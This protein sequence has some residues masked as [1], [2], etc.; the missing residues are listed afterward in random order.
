MGRRTRKRIHKK[1]KGTRKR[2][3]SSH[4]MKFFNWW[5]NTQGNEE[6]SES[7]MQY[8]QEL[9]KGCSNKFK[10]V[11]IYSVFPPVSKDNDVTTSDDILTFQYSGE[12]ML[13]ETSKFKINIGPGED[14]HENIIVSPYM[15]MYMW[16]DNPDFSP[17]T[18]LRKHMRPQNKFCLFAVSNEA[19]ER[20]DFFHKLS[21]YK[22]VDS[23]GSILNNLGKKCPG[24]NYD[25]KEYHDFIGDYKFMICFENTSKKNYMT[26][27]LFIAY[28]SGTIP[29]YWGCPNIGDYVNVDSILYLKPDFS[30]ADVSKL[31]SDI[32]VL[33]ND[34]NLYKKKF[35]SIFFK[36]GVIPDEFNMDVI[37]SKVC[38][39]VGGSKQL[40]IA[41]Y[42]NSL[43]E[44]G[45]SIALFD[46][47][48]FNQSLLNNKSIIIYNKNSD[49]N[50]DK[51]VD[52]FND[53]FDVFSISSDLNVQEID[54]ILYEEKCDIIYIIYNGVRI[55]VPKNAK[56]CAHCVFICVE[57]KV[58][59]VYA[60]IS[61]YVDG[62]DG[63]YPIVPHMINLPSH[64]RNMR[65]KLSIPVNATVFGRY[66]GN[67]TFD[68]DYVHKAV[69]EVAKRNNNIYF[70]FANTDT[71]CDDLPNIIHLEAVI[72]A[73]EKVEFI[74][75]CDAMLW[76]GLKGETFGLAIGEFSTK[77]KPVFVTEIGVKGFVDILKDK[78][79][80]YNK[81]TLK[82]L[83]INFNKEDYK[84][85][86]LN[87]YKE[88]SPENVMKK[89]KEVFIDTN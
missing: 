3:G 34:A 12:S 45:T 78:G 86:D 61:P 44:R 39:M 22:K 46:Y 1:R 82:N 27:K 47:A 58:G 52:K 59:D 71:F 87:G 23:C 67:N 81:N 13:G 50:N 53:S 38:G 73:R 18:K 65:N 29:I 66:G 60:A 48:Y 51:I 14:E 56:V 69:Y 55:D 15:Q 75:T 10:E 37:N 62:N 26:E 84:N 63:K 77:N 40:K 2:G 7:E 32:K 89:F 16:I 4:N 17:H 68:I 31:I 33:D 41:F 11:H 76:G 49:N 20:N 35:E 6:P 42:D 28:N 8:F 24:N 25:S 57:P 43:S 74:N 54:K 70:L 80:W 5:V 83:L 30:D 19:R 88:F 9:L 72:D 21:N 36:D 64:N 85:K 79:I